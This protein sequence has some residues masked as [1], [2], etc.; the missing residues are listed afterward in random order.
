MGS[1]ADSESEGLLAQAIVTLDLDPI[2][3]PGRR[4]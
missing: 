4:R 1:C 3:E 2:S